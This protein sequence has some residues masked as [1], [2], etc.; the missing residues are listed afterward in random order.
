M[1]AQFDIKLP[2]GL[3]RTVPM[4]NE[5]FLHTVGVSTTEFLEKTAH[6]MCCL[7]KRAVDG[8]IVQ[9]S[10]TDNTVL[11]ITPYVLQNAV[12]TLRLL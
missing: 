10:C 3:Y 4:D 6:S 5:D 2:E 11:L 7:L 8:E 1:K 9:L 12:L